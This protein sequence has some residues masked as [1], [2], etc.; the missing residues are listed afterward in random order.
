MT[1]FSAAA[2]KKPSQGF[3]SRPLSGDFVICAFGSAPGAE[4]SGQRRPKLNALRLRRRKAELPKE[5]KVPRQSRGL[6]KALIQVSRL[7]NRLRHAPSM[8]QSAA[9]TRST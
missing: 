2:R 9:G 1:E 4:P 6:L 5:E 8:A 3:L 7:V